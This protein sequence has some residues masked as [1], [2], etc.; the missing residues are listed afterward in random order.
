V[1][2]TRALG[3]TEAPF[4]FLTIPPIVVGTDPMV[5][6]ICVVKEY[7]LPLG[8]MADTADNAMN[9][10]GLFVGKSQLRQIP[11]M[12]FP[13]STGLNQLVMPTSCV[14]P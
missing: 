7:E 13:P 10:H 2:F 4:A 12:Y 8:Q 9:Q 5:E 14:M 11:K 6:V 3:V 1:L